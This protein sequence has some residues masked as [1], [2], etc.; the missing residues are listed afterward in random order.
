MAWFFRHAWRAAGGCREL[1]VDRFGTRFQ[2]LQTRRPQRS[3]LELPHRRGRGVALP[4]AT[5]GVKKTMES[6]N[7]GAQ[8]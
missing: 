6:G 4:W 3:A 1:H 2:G 7:T 8:N 5:G